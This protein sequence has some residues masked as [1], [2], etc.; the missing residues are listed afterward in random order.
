MKHVFYKLTFALV[1]LAVIAGCKKDETQPIINEAVVDSNTMSTIPNVS[2]SVPVYMGD[3][4]TIEGLNLMNVSEVTFTYGETKE[5]K[6]AELT[7]QEHKK[8]GFIVPAFNFAQS[9]LTYP[10]SLRI[11]DKNKGEQPVFDYDFFISVPITDVVINTEDCL[12]TTE[13]TVGDEVTITG[14][15]LMQVAAVNFAGVTVEDFE[16][17]AVSTTVSTITF[18]VPASDY[19]AGDNTVAIAVVWGGT[20]TSVTEEF[21]VRTPL[22]NAYEGAVPVLDSE[23]SFT[24]DN[25]DL[26]S[27]FMWGEFEFPVVEQSNDALTLKIPSRLSEE[28]TGEMAA[29]MTAV[30]GEPAQNVTLLTGLTIDVT[31]IAGAAL[32]EASSVI[33]MDGGEA[34]PYRFFLA[35]EVTVTGENLDVI[36]SIEVGG[37]AATVV[38]TPTPLEYKFMVPETLTFNMEAEDDG[39]VEVATEFEIIAKFNGGEEASFGTVMVYPMYFYPDVCIG[40]A[41]GTSSLYTEFAQ[42][43]AFFM[44]NDGKVISA[45]DWF[46][47]AVD[48]FA[49][50]DG[51]NKVTKGNKI[52]KAA[53]TAEEY[54]SVAPYIFLNSDSSGKVSLY[55]ASNSSS[56]LKAHR[57]VNAEDGSNDNLPSAYGTPITFFRRVTSSSDAEEITSGALTKLYQDDSTTSACPALKAEPGSTSEWTVGSVMMVAYSTYE[58]GAAKPNAWS[59]S[60]RFGYLHVKEVTC[61]DLTTGKAT[62]DRSGYIKFDFY[63][64]PERNLDK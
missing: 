37:V 39:D 36:E 4:I 6:A 13:A 3:E 60:R 31:P 12:S 43:N 55:S 56:A 47:N 14:R 46:Y 15:N 1:A 50:A 51:G 34:A 57:Y 38:G 45:T 21:V 42:Q 52:D 63:W 29:D 30:Y 33:P 40:L 54:Y 28:I 24:G 10:V 62:D 23:I 61:A 48:P 17:K 8:I 19:V 25:L 64:S 59:G 58:H 5:E 41:T 22:M 26:A 44:P 16:A 27:T 20:E 49:I 53:A 35:K 2:G 18:A 32:P 11:F 9:D 7:L